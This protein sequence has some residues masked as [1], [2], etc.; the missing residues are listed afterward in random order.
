[1]TAASLVIAIDG[2]AASG[3]GTLA[4][5]LADY[6]H[7]PHLDTGLTYRAV[8][9][10]LLTKGWPLGD[11]PHAVEA[12]RLVDLGSLDRNVLSAHAVGEAASKIA[13]IPEVRRILVDK[14]R[15]FAAQVSGAVLDGRD[16]GTVVCPDATVKLYVTASAEVR[17]RRRLAEIEA[18]DG[19]GDFATILADIARRD[20]RDMGRVDSPLRPAADAH[21]LDT[22]EMDIETAFIAARTIIDGIVAAE[23]ES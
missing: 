6:Y 8:A 13:V 19:T 18:R 5:R 2:P 14:Q 15:A 20:E 16:I 1:M 9:H 3:K 23:S 12:A 10:M 7:L 4:R 11:A 21:L 22:S 17:A